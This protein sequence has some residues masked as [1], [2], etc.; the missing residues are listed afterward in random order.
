VFASQQEW[1]RSATLSYSFEREPQTV[2]HYLFLDIPEESETR[3]ISIYFKQTH[4]ENQKK[5]YVLDGFVCAVIFYC[6]QENFNL[7]VK[8]RP[9]RR[10]LQ[11]I[12]LFMESWHRWF[13]SIYSTIVI[14]GTNNSFNIFSTITDWLFRRPKRDLAVTPLSGGVDSTFTLLRHKNSVSLSSF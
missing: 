6:M 9:S 10:F 1:I 7:V 14:S 11:N 13:P 3:R 8:G 2:T 5:L 4:Y 12:N